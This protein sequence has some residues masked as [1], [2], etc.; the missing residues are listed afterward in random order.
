MKVFLYNPT[1]Q[2]GLREISRDVSLAPASVKKYLKDIEKENLIESY[3]EKNSPVYKAKRDSQ[4]FKTF[5]KLSIIYELEESGFID[6]LWNEICPE[7]IILFGSYSKGEAIEQSDIDIFL[8]TK[9]KRKDINITK[10][11]KE[12]SSEI[13]IFTDELKNIQKHLKA[14]LYNGI[15]LR[16]YLK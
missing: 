8:V 6:Y 1:T 10:Y 3:I 16:G 15:I 5:Q 2:F 12:F 14:N 13:Q 4:K 11:Q 9:K 7:T